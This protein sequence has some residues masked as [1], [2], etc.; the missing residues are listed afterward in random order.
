[1]IQLHNVDLKL[2]RVFD[3]VVK[4]GG[5]SAAQATLNAGQSTVSEQ[6][7]QLETRLGVKLCDRGRGGFRLTEQGTAIHAA[8][9]TLLAAVDKFRQEADIH[10]KQVSGPLNFGVIDNTVTDPDAPVLGAVRRFLARRYDV[11]ISIYV[12]SPAELE[13]RVL[14]GRLHAAIGHFPSKVAGLAYTRL[15]SETHGL[16]CGRSHALY[17]AEQRGAE[18]MRRIVTADIVA[19]G[20]MQRME[21]KAL[22]AAKATATV[23]NVEAQALLIHSGAYIGFLPCH[24]AAQWVTS[25]ELRQLAPARATLQ[26]SFETITRRGVAQ[27]VVV[28]AFLEELSRRG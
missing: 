21:L 4:C 1:M 3:A 20:Y 16:Y 13:T 19:R 27:P 8:T 10:K 7:G 5:F 22:G 6:M 14:D 11:H 15:Y 24:Y 26:S 2:L 25:G 18:L 17:G 12:G 9:Q 28:Q 23:D